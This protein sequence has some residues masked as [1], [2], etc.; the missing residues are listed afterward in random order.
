MFHAHPT[1]TLLITLAAL[2]VLAAVA[3]AL[4]LNFPAFPQSAAPAPAGFPADAPAP[5]PQDYIEAQQGFQYLVSYTD[6]GFAPAAL[7]VKQGETVRFTNNTSEPLQL[8][9]AGAQPP[10]LDRGEYFEYTFATSGSFDYSD[11]TN[12]GIVTVQ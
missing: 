9:L 6:N 10:V 1:R 2:L 7:S 8:T 5:Q 4:R 11:G 12:N 3:Y